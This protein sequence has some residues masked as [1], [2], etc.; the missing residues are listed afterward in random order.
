MPRLTLVQNL[1]SHQIG[2][3]TNSDFSSTAGLLHYLYARTFHPFL[4]PLN[5]TRPYT[6]P[7]LLLSLQWVS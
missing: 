6:R 5:L 1:R 3:A 4:L 7:F 2:W